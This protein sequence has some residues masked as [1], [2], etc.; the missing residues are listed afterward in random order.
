[1]D[2]KLGSQARSLTQALTSLLD[3]EEGLFATR[4]EYLKVRGRAKGQGNFVI[5]L[6]HDY[7]RLADDIAFS[8]KS[9]AI[10]ELQR[11]EK[12][13]ET[14][15]LLLIGMQTLTLLALLLAVFII[16]ARVVKRLKALNSNIQEQFDQQHPWQADKSRDEIGEL[17][18]T[19]LAFSETIAAQKQ[20][21]HELSM[22]DGLTGIANRRHFDFRL[23]L[24]IAQ[25][26]RQNYPLSVILLDVDF[27]KPF[28]DNYGHGAGDLALK[29]VAEALA[30]AVQRKQDLVARY[31]GEEF[32]CL[33][34]DTD[35]NGAMKVAE[36]IHKAIA[37]LA[38]PH[39]FS[40][41]SASL[42]CS[43]GVV[44]WQGEDSR[45]HDDLLKSADDALYRAKLEGRNRS[46]HADP[47][48][49][50]ATK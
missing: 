21:L 38:I 6:I 1:M 37:A 49:L 13:V 26:R 24:D 4:A 7:T 30:H 35:A 18:R 20:A 27:F 16:H 9:D 32:A 39:E 43:I 22:T 50:T 40:A 34:P 41:V 15:S 23:D 47:S 46:I 28:N 42:T 45:T 31:G 33:L 19:L 36:L 2:G 5:N 12:Q 48:S 11:L 3:A 8:R 44:T 10:D 17:S 14:Q 25:A 29:S